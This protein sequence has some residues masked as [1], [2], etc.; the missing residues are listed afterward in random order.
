MNV[1]GIN[2]S[3]SQYAYDPA[4]SQAKELKKSPDKVQITE[5]EKF[6]SGDLQLE[7]MVKT[8]NTTYNPNYHNLRFEKS[9]YDGYVIQIYDK[10][11]DKLVRQIP[12]EELLK[13]KM[14]IEQYKSGDFFN[15]KA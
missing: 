9:E 2:T 11:S 4:S 1:D 10:E 14:K 13:L 8:V 3:Q 7:E 12:P 6:E 15:T 5:V